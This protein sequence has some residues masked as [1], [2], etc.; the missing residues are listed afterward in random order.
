MNKLLILVPEEKERLHLAQM[1]D[2]FIEEGGEIFFA[3]TPTQALEIIERE[4][5]KLLFIEE[6]VIDN[7]HPLWKRENLCIALIARMKREKYPAKT[8]LFKPL[9]QTKVVEVCEKVFGKGTPHPSLPP[10]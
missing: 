6:N 3:D 5:P 8:V 4:K 2:T 9:Q 10:M 1:L 7:D